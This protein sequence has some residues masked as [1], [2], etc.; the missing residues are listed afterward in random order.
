MRFMSSDQQ[1]ARDALRAAW[2]RL[3]SEALPVALKASQEDAAAALVVRDLWPA[4]RPDDVTRLDR[5]EQSFLLR[6][7]A[8]PDGFDAA[9]IQALAA[10][11][12]E[13]FRTTHAGSRHARGTALRKLVRQEVEARQVEIRDEA[14]KL[15]E[16][17]H[18]HW[19]ASP[20]AIRGRVLQ[21]L[22]DRLLDELLTFGGGDD[23]EPKRKL[24]LVTALATLGG[25]TSRR[26]DHLRKVGDGKTAGFPYVLKFLSRG[27]WPSMRSF[28]ADVEITLGG[29]HAGPGG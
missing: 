28:P 10:I 9:L 12:E 4:M 16:A 26:A 6:G 19:F 1:A 8:R 15:F 2:P 20:A 22:S 5:A 17:R 24:K 23:T 25:S 13:R 18:S 14:D 21:E 11:A 29:V 27:H 7:G 3:L